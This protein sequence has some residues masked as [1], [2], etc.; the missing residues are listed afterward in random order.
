MRIGIIR[1]QVNL[2]DLELLE[3][4]NIKI[5][6]VNIKRTYTKSGSSKIKYE[7][8]HFVSP[9]INLI[10]L[11]VDEAIAKLDKYVDDA[12]ITHL[13]SIRIIHGRGTGA[14]KHAISEYCRKS[15]LILDYKLG[16]FD[17]GGDGVTIATLKDQ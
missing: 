7:K 9:E 5:D 14:L 17:E 3:E 2:R 6:N 11:T 15:S 10:G 13:S 4:N 8:S 1:S 12:Y 16:N